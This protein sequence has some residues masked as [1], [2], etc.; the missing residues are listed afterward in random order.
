MKQTTRKEA[1]LEPMIMSVKHLEKKWKSLEN[2]KTF[3]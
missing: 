2:E 1:T 3:L